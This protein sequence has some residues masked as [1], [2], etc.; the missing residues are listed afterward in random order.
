[1]ILISTTMIEVGINI[2]NATL[3]IIEEANK[4]GLAQLH[5]LEE[6]YQEVIYL[7]I[8]FYYTIIIY[9]KTL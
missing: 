2:P 4:F 5:Q 7:Q 6:E 8:V 1:M 3:I 9:Q